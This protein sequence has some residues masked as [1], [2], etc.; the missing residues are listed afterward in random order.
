MEEF[1]INTS[2][3]LKDCLLFTVTI[4]SLTHS[5]G[6]TIPAA[7]LFRLRKITVK[8]TSWRKVFLRNHPC[9][10]FCSKGLCI[11]GCLLEPTSAQRDFSLWSKERRRHHL[12]SAAEQ[13]A[14]S[15]AGPSIIIWGIDAPHVAMTGSG[16]D[17]SDWEDRF[18]YC[19]SAVMELWKLL[20]W[21]GVT[22]RHAACT[23]N[24][25]QGT[26]FYYEL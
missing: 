12:S 25:R 7:S 23:R 20:W 6:V 26:Q 10:C 8:S 22:C 18:R 21:K 3:A 17:L 13:N 11:F 2:A 4:L 5:N 15:S 1:A 14:G 19:T 24:Y 16:T 9:Y